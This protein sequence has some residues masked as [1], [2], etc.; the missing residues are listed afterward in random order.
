M[1]CQPD[2]ATRGRAAAGVGN[3]II[4]RRCARS[5]RGSARRPCESRIAGSPIGPGLLVLL[6]VAHTDDASIADRLA[7]K[8]RA[9]RVF[10]DA[11]GH[12][13]EPLGERESFA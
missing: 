5:C 7:E 13:N 3:A 6:G 10:A 12:M 9:L 11:H 1:R 8:V 4:A 2:P